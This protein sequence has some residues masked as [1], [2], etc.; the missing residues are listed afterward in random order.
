MTSTSHALQRRLQ[1]GLG[2]VR[3]VTLVWAFFV[4]CID[5]NS[6]VLVRPVPAF[7]LLGVL[8]LW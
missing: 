5:T 2:A 7:G 8:V 3:A 1:L 4:V 6:G